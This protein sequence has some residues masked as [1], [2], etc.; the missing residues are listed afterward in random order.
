MKIVVNHLTRMRA[1]YICV[2]GIEVETGQHVRPVLGGVNLGT[3]L[4]ARHGGP[5]DMAALVDLGRAAAVGHPPETEDVRF[6]RAQARRAGT[7][8]PARFWDLLVKVAH[9][10]LTAIFGPAL[11]SQGQGLV[12]APGSGQ[13][14][15][16]CLRPAVR[17]HLS[18]NAEGK[19]RLVFT[20]PKNN[21]T[22]DLAVTDLRLY[23]YKDGRYAPKAAVIAQVAQR[24]EQGV[25]FILS[26]GL[27]RAFQPLEGGPAQHWLQVNNLHLADDPAWRAE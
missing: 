17:P 23:D 3:G 22:L 4:L 24:I 18:L 6:E 21:R 10:N 16:G 14:S 26:V 2:A 12:V 13:A 1:G 7:M 9:P 20:F 8:P 5:F 25:D 11:K 27:G 15:L 19:V